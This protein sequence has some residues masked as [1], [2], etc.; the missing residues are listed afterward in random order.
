MIDVFSL[1]MILLYAALHG[2]TMKLADLFN[3]HDV[4]WF[5]GDSLLFGFIWGGFGA[6]IILSNQLLGTIYLAMVFAFVLRARTDY[7]NH[8]IANIIMFF[9]YFYRYQT[10]NWQPL[11]L[12]FV[13][14]AVFGL[15]SDRFREKKY[16]K[17]KILKSLRTLSDLR[18]HYYWF[19]LIYSIVT[20]VWLVFL[21]VGVNMFAYEMVRQIYK[22]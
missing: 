13:I 19:P 14:F 11:L 22:K 1:P 10:I 9:T 7:L 8:G 20:G 6:L 4:R 3:E 16:P 12:F 5:R 21:T 18:T 2:I 17:D 15:I